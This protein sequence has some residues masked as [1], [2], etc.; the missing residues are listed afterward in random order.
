MI[1]FQCD[2]T[3]GCHPSILAALQ[4]TNLEQ[5]PGYGT[6]PYCQQ[7]REAI[8]ALCQQPQAQVHFLVGGTQANAT[9]IASI[10]KAHQGVISSEMAISPPMRPAPSRPPAT[11]S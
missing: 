10:L 9:V 3:E 5:T 11:R 2:Y 8:L 7:A 4:K 6:D 1:Q